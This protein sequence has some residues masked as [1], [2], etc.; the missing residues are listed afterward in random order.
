MFYLELDYFALSEIK[1][2]ESFPSAQ[3]NIDG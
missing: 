2:N 1:V 3:F